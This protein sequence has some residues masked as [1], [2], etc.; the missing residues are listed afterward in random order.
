MDNEIAKGKNWHRSITNYGSGGV[1]GQDV[2]G[3]HSR[4]LN[5]FVHPKELS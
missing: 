3:A 1:L 4:S 2:V 5:R